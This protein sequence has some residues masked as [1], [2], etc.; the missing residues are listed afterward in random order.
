MNDPI[1]FLKNCLGFEWDAGNSK[2]NWDRH[3][4]NKWESEQVFFNRPLIVSPD[5]THSETENRYYLLGQTDFGR[6]LFVVFTIRGDRVRI[7]S[8]RDMNKRER[9]VWKDESKENS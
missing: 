5:V 3:L 4:V 8:A 2:K 7:I 6:H 1:G 9:E